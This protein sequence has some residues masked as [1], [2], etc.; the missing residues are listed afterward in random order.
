MNRQQKRAWLFQQRKDIHRAPRNNVTA[1]ALRALE[2]VL[3]KRHNHH[4]HR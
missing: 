4:K 2:R 3:H 1:I